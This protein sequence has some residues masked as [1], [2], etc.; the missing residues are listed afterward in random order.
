MLVPGC[1]GTFPALR[2]GKPCQLS[3]QPPDWLP[4]SSAFRPATNSL[5]DFESAD[6]RLTGFRSFV[7]ALARQDWV[8]AHLHANALAYQV[9]AVQ[10]AA[11]DTDPVLAAV[12]GGSLPAQVITAGGGPM[13]AASGEP[14]SPC[15]RVPRRPMTV[16]GTWRRASSG[17]AW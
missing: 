8:Q 14:G 13:P 15:Q 4:M 17:R 10:E 12:Y 7:E 3:V 6:E 1:C 5:P 16:A 2:S 11:A 9:V